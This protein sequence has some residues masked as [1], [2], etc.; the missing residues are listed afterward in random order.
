MLHGFRGDL[1]DGPAARR[2]CN[3]SANGYR[4]PTEAEWEKAARGGLSGKSFPWG[5]HD[6]PQPG[7][8]LQRQFLQLRCEPDAGLPSDLRD[9]RASLH[10]AGGEFRGEWLRAV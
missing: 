4:L 9:G 1:Q 8:L 5:R 10:F 7:E 3:W 2:M 6:Q